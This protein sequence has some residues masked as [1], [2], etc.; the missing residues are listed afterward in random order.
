MNLERNGKYLI[1]INDSEIINDNIEY[2]EGTYYEELEIDN[3]DI[4]LDEINNLSYIGNAKIN[5]TTDG[6]DNYISIINLNFIFRIE[7]E[8][9]GSISR[10]SI[11]MTTGNLFI[12]QYKLMDI[13]IYINTIAL[14][15]KHNRFITISIIYSLYTLDR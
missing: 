2:A 6:I 8:N 15:I 5:S 1:Y 9:K 11:E 14:S 10:K 13:D 7:I 12:S 4:S 3:E